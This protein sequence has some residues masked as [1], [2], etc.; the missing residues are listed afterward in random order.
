MPWYTAGDRVAN[1]RI[2]IEDIIRNTSNP[3]T[4]LSCA[5]V[6]HILKRLLAICRLLRRINIALTRRVELIKPR[7]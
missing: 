6:H 4:G 3:Y 5:Q 2:L 7:T 1:I